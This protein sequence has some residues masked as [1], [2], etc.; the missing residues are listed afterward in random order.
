VSRVYAAAVGKPHVQQ[1]HIKGLLHENR[2]A[3]FD[4]PG[5]R[6]PP[7]LGAELFLHQP[8]NRLFIVHNKYLHGLHERCHD[9]P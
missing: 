8:P 4:G 1:D 6:N 2:Q 7:P 3:F 9:S 5:G